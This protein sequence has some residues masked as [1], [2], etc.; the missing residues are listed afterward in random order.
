MDLTVALVN[1]SPVAIGPP[2]F[3]AIPLPSDSREGGHAQDDEKVLHT[4]QKIPREFQ[5][6]AHILEGQ[7]V[8]AVLTAFG[9]DH[10]IDAIVVGLSP[11]SLARDI[12]GT[13]S[14]NLQKCA[15]LPVWSIPWRG[16]FGIR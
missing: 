1:Q 11:H 6:R 2:T 8:A 12:L 14:G 13:A 16:A 9:L 15:S 5:P 4:T 10:N 7:P 3:S